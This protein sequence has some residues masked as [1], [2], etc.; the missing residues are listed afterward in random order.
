V[1]TIRVPLE[2]FA[3][4]GATLVTAGV[5]GE[6]VVH[7][8]GGRVAVAA[9]LCLLLGA[10]A[11]LAPRHLVVA[12]MVWLTALGTLRRLLTQAGWSTSTDPLLLV[13]PFAIVLLAVVAVR[14]KQAQRRS[15][16]TT[17][18]GAL[19]LLVVLGALNPAQGGPSVGFSGL[20]FVL[21]PM[22]A[23]WIG[24]DLCDD[25][26]M[27]RLLQLIG[28]LALAA[29][30]YGLGQTLI[31]FPSWDKAWIENSG[32]AALIVGNTSRA[33]ASF[34]SAAEYANYLAV[35]LV[36]WIAFWLR[37]KWAVVASVGAA[38]LLAAIF[39]ES[40][41]GVLV[42]LLFAVGVVYASQKRFP[43]LL[44]VPVGA[45]CIVLLVLGISRFAPTSTGTGTVAA[46]EQH[47]VQGL[48][49]PLDPQSSTLL[50]HLNLVTHGIK[51]AFSDPIGRGTG[52]ITKAGSKFGGAS[53]Q[54]ESDPSNL[55]VALGLPGLVAYIVV[56]VL[57]FRTVYSVAVRR[58]DRLA[59]VALAIVT[60]IAFSWLIGG[61]YAVA[62]LPWLAMGWADG[63][64]SR[65]GRSG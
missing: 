60:L 24:R 2:R 50:V 56:F 48:S 8:A 1:N 21:I 36:I 51:T 65:Q 40:S 55:A 20:L 12:L 64:L 25:A 15:A 35:G 4:P 39:L 19:C 26:L 47:Q 29:A 18:I 7:G 52:V 49:N 32:Y 58:Q 53:R 10:L 3:W 14:S 57:A 63:W 13:G 31:G 43:L 41:R 16:L 5:T 62:P 61:A 44:S 42:M 9:G 54:T 34:S 11:F 33:F 17:A 23:F 22:V 45:V 27:T 59:R 30:I 37:S 28:L 38:V 6:L 46:L